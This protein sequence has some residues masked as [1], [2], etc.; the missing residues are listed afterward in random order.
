MIRGILL[1]VYQVYKPKT[2]WST[3]VFN[4]NIFGVHY[5][6]WYV[7]S[8]RGCLE[9]IRSSR[10]YSSIS[11]MTR[12]I[13]PKVLFGLLYDIDSCNG[14]MTPRRTVNLHWIAEL[15][16]SQR[17]RSRCLN[18]KAVQIEVRINNLWICEVWFDHNRKFAM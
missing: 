15:E 14:T 7:K 6:K 12:F 3:I 4:S 1:W 18:D 11:V 16:K 17:Y 5:H 10:D 8:V 2:G 13:F 9:Q